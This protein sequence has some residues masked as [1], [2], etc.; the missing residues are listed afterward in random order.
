MINKK[1]LSPFL[2]ISFILLSAIAAAQVKETFE[3]VVKNGISQGI[4]KKNG[5]KV[6]YIASPAQDT[7]KI[8][9]YYEDLINKS[10]KPYQFSFE[11]NAAIAQSKLKNTQVTNTVI[12]PNPKNANN[13]S[14]IN[15]ENNN[16]ERSIV[17]PTTT[18]TPGNA[19]TG[20]GCWIRQ[21]VFGE[22]HYIDKTEEYTFDVPSDVTSIRIE[23]WSGGGNGS[24]EWTHTERVAHE[25]R[26]QMLSGV[27]GG[28][29]GGGAYASAIIPVKKGDHVFIS[30][31]AGGGGKSVQVKLNNNTNMFYLNNGM[32]GSENGLYGKGY[33]GNSGGNYGVFKN[34][35]Y[36]LSGG[37]GLKS[38]ITNYTYHDAP[39]GDGMLLPAG[40]ATQSYDINF[41]M[42]GSAAILNNGGRAAYISNNGLTQQAAATNGGFPGGGG[43][44][45]DITATT[46]VSAGKGAPGMVIIHY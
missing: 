33:G 20:G 16:S 38:L 15:V 11:S 7:V 22:L 9:S 2:L 17:P 6:I 34:N 46:V 28:G 8:R 43:G 25:V 40:I 23:A 42:G 21:K 26:Q 41:G 14:T 30:I 24:I 36:W 3:S 35:I 5:Y 44:G 13:P 29:G 18:G 27:K 32:D 37:M 45:G 12:Q 4:I 1:I 10:G 31:P 19:V 39:N